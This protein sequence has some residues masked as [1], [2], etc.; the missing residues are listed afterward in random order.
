MPQHALYGLFLL[1]QYVLELQPISKV[2]HFLRPNLCG[3]LLLILNPLALL[4]RH[5]MAQI[6][7]LHFNIILFL[8]DNLQGLNRYQL[9]VFII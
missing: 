3:L 1:A 6:L 9:L 4:L 7:P 5:N 2:Q 8:S